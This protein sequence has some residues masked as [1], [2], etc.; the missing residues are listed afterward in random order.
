MTANLSNQFESRLCYDLTATIVIATD[1]DLSAAV[2]LNGT[3]LVGIIVPAN[4]DGTGITL[5]ASDTIDGTFV[6][7]QTDRTSATP[8]PITTTA[9][10]YVPI[11]NLQ[12]TEGLRFIKIG[13][14]SA[15]TTTNTVFKLVT[16]AR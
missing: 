13:T 10:R 11:D 2:D 14:A 6:A 7:V 15:Q 9:S 12:I 16:K 3:Q 4:F 8:Y 5:N 1:D